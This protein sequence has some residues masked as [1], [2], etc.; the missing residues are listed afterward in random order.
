M[1]QELIILFLSAMIIENAVFA[2]GLVMGDVLRRTETYQ[3]IL[4]FG[5]FVAVVASL[6]GAFAW[7]AALAADRWPALVQCWWILL[8]LCV[9]AA[10]GLVLAA[11]RF[12]M[13]KS[14]AS[15]AP[16]EQ[17]LASAAFNGAVFAAV[18]LAAA[19]RLSLFQTVVYCLGSAAGLT[20][21]MMLIHSG[22]ERMELSEVPRAFRGLPVTM[23]YIGILCLA[24]YGLI[25]HQLPA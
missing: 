13:K 21:A 18:L 11:L 16:F 25:G 15:G 3:S 22:R 5:G 2:R 20:L 9:T 1:I 24:I 23:I 14:G 19:D 4:W 7:G 17:L 8:M 12:K 10:Y 6:A